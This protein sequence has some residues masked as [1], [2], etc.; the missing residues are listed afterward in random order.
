[1]EYK[2][3]D[4]AIYYEEHGQ[5]KPVLCLH[6]FTE[7]HRSMKGCLEPVFA[8]VNGYRRIYLD[9]PGMGKTPAADW[10]KN[11]DDMLDVLKQ[12][13][14]GVIGDEGFLLVGTSYGGYMS[15]GLAV[16]GK[17]NIDGIFMYGPCVV[18]DSDERKL[19]D[20][21]DDDLFV[22]DGLEDEFE[23]DEDFE[24]FLNEAVQATR[25]VWERYKAEILPAYKI[26]NSEFCK[27][28]RKNGYAL[29]TE[30]KFGDLEL[31]KPV[32]VMAGKQ[33]EG[34]GYEDAWDKLNHLPKLTYVALNGT[35]HFMHLENPAAFN[36][37]LQDWLT[38]I[39]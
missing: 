29:S 11:A 27:N 34:V 10:I 8:G 39:K 31:N 22:E 35:G 38:K 32:T 23:D 36:F 9:M 12:F 6:G 24:D 33:D 13:I 2:V 17:T 21:E 1:M 18:S 25:E 7:D 15:L 14:Q 16:D 30:A 20:V 3:R 4:L 19:P 26:A 5:G 28:Y 37:H